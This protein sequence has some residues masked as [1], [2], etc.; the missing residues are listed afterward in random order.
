MDQSPNDLLDKR[1]EAETKLAELVNIY[2]RTKDDGTDIVSIGSNIAVNGAD[3]YNNLTTMAGKTKP[4][5]SD[6][7]IYI[8]GSNPT[9][10]STSITGGELAGIM[11]SRDTVVKGYM[12]QLNDL[13][14][15]LIS[16][17]NKI[18][19][20]GA[21]N[22]NFFNGYNADTMVIN[23]DLQNNPNKINYS[24]YTNNDIASI[25]ANLGNKVLNTFVTGS[26]AV[27]VNASTTLASLGIGTGSINI[28]NV[29][30]NFTGAETISDLVK[31][32][33]NNVG[34]ISIVF[35]Q[36]SNTFFMVGSDPFTIQE[37]DTSGKSV[38]Q[39]LGWSEE[40]DSAALINASASPTINSVNRNLPFDNGNPQTTQIYKFNTPANT[41]GYANGILTVSYTN[42]VTNFNGAVNWTTLSTPTNVTLGIQATGAGYLT[43]NF[44]VNTQQIQIKY[45]VYSPAVN[46]YELFPIT[47]SD[48]QGNMTQ[49]MNLPGTERFADVYS[50][51]VGQLSGQLSSGNNLLSGY[52]GRAIAVQDNAVECHGGR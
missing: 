21:T 3:G 52:P 34:N 12:N 6:V 41:M 23:Q 17:V 20:S 39:T 31:S 4:E 35:N 16:T 33:N 22:E 48:K 51:M 5:L 44:N 29:T 7:G 28:N 19:L 13:A 25:V 47:L 2:I 27:A 15:S 11:Q 40:T 30:V 43:T 9:D 14:G 10:I 32:I 36:A 50:T 49:V 38:L 1:N 18:H 8:N 37:N 45:N 24:L 26:P 42:G 46:T